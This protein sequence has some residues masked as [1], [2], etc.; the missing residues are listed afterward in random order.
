LINEA[1]LEW[2]RRVT[3][4]NPQ[5][6]RAAQ[7]P[8][9]R[10]R[11]S[12]ARDQGEQAP[13]AA[14]ARSFKALFSAWSNIKHKLPKIV[15]EANLGDEDKAYVKNQ[16]EELFATFTLGLA[17][18]LGAID[19]AERNSSGFETRRNEYSLQQE[20]P[21]PVAYLHAAE[22]IA[23]IYKEKFEEKAAAWRQANDNPMM[24]IGDGIGRVLDEIIQTAAVKLYDRGYPDPLARWDIERPA[25]ND[26]QSHLIGMRDRAGYD[27]ETRAAE[28]RQP[29][30]SSI[31]ARSL[32]GTPATGEPPPNPVP[33]E[34]ASE[35]DATRINPALRGVSIE[36]PTYLPSGVLRLPPEAKE[37]SDSG[38]EGHGRGGGVF[39]VPPDDET[40]DERTQRLF[41]RARQITARR[42]RAQGVPFPGLLAD[43]Q[44][45]VNTRSLSREATVSALTRRN[46]APSIAPTAAESGSPEGRDYAVRTRAAMARARELAALQG[47]SEASDAERDSADG[48]E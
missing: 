33:T 12:D 31:S 20:F 29:V 24:A 41:K 16:L 32:D 18:R 46:V 2:I 10:D 19:D 21:T 3:T 27:T 30:A 36:N 22:K 15:D 4:L 40:Q 5:L 7:L 28:Q 8:A 14:G 23:R 47:E 44:L 13:V 25:G 43:V 17:D 9:G 6:T 11:C 48:L 26:A 37:D 39:D 45:R 35:I 42:L 34:A 38:G 1:Q